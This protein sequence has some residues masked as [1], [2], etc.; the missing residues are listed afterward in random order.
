M[1][2]KTIEMEAALMQL[3]NIKNTPQKRGVRI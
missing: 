2:I 3:K 1:G